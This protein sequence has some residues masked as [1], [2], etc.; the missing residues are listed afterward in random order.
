MGFLTLEETNKRHSVKQRWLL[1]ACGADMVLSVAQLTAHNSG[2]W[3][4]IFLST[5]S[6]S[7]STNQAGQ[8]WL[9]TARVLARVES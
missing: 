5:I 9:V 1:P 8:R 2:L 4:R 3:W 6:S 7:D